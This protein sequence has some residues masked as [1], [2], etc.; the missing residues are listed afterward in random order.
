MRRF[1]DLPAPQSI[2]IETTKQRGDEFNFTGLLL[3]GCVTMAQRGRG[4]TL[5]LAASIAKMALSR[6]RAS[7]I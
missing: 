1:P 5:T 3:M 2:N 7:A 4:A 6:Q